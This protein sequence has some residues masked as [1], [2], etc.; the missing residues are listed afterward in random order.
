MSSMWKQP[1]YTPR[2][3]EN[4]WVN[5]IFETH[6]QFCNCQ[7]TWL[8]LLEVLNKQGNARKPLQ[9]INNIRCLLTGKEDT[10][11]D[12]KEEESTGFFPGELERLFDED[13]DK[14]DQENPD[15]R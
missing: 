7:D 14:E 8:H 4:K 5:I 1:L 10:T 13:G 6:D 3:Q 12:D 11:K 15:T 9:D 2:S